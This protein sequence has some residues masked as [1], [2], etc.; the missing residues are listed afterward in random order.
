MKTHEDSRE[1]NDK[2]NET[3][4]EDLF[5]EM[6]VV[7]LEERLELAGRCVCRNTKAAAVAL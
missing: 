3:G 5:D 4:A 7:E 6:S 1:V 2:R